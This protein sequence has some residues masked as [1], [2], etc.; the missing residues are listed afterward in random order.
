MSSKKT[1]P[2]EKKLRNSNSLEPKQNLSSNN[3]ISTDM[4]ADQGF[5][6]ANKITLAKKKKIVSQKYKK[7]T[8][9]II[10]RCRFRKN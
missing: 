6:P 4:V 5:V 8:F 3:L 7:G 9:R 1:E 2:T 10:I